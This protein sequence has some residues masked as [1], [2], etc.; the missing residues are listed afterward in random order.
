[1]NTL[2][3][4][5]CLPGFLRKY[6]QK[7]LHRIQLE[8][9]LYQFTPSLKG[10]ILDVGSKSRRYDYLM[11]NKPMA[12][13]IVRNREKEIEYGDVNDLKFKDEQF[14]SVLCIE[15][16]EYI[17]TPEKAI[18]EIHRVLKKSGTLVLSVP[19]MYKI[20]DDQMRFTENYLREKLLKGFSHVKIYPLGN[21]Y[22]IIL[23]I[24]RGKIRA[25]KSVLLKSILY[26]LYLF[27]VLFVPLS[28]ISRDRDFVS[29]Y[30]I[31][32]IK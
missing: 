15:V 31:K 6:I 28:K 16:F 19:F 22:T 11:E 5:K 4:K 30:I 26:G 3:I 12:I 7:S 9:Y 24:I 10:K 21:F 13:D 2:F 25:L 18:S 23:D 17:S 20:H 27:L 14:E 8:K 32:A 29:G 1:M